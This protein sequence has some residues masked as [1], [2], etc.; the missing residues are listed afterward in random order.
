VT[1]R[2]FLLAEHGLVPGDAITETVQL[3]V[4]SPLTLGLFAGKWCSYAAGPDLA[5]DQ[6]QED[7][8]ALVFESDP[9]GEPLEI[10]GAVEME[11][12]LSSDKPLAMVAVRLSDVAADDKATRVTYGLL[13]L[14]HRDSRE[15]PE[16][17][18]PGQF[19]RVRVKLNDAAQVFPKSHRVRIS[20][21]T[22][23]WPLAWPSPSPVRLTVN[24]GPSFVDLPVR[25]PRSDDAHLRPFEAPEGAAPAPRHHVEPGR[26]NWLIHRDLAS[27]KSTLE[28]INDNGTVYLEDIDL[29]VEN[30]A[31]EQYSS[32]DDDFL[33][34]KGDTRLVRGLKRG[35]WSVRTVAHTVLTSTETEF[36]IA[37]DLDAW[38]GGDRVFSRNWNVSIPRDLM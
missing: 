17:L 26:H 25:A 30:R 23:Y 6:R 29:E 12:E 21:S 37:A 11:M 22:S 16:A 8:G 24:A 34:V 13:N 3:T 1:P 4:Q 2:R 18:V 28:V 35:D 5:H 36:R 14:T 31:F 19:Y 20:I 32:W 7:G 15:E 38:E 27:D 33:S 10:L 9:L